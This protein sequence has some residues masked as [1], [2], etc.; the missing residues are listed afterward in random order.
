[1]DS[2]QMTVFFNQNSFEL[3]IDATH[4]YAVLVIENIRAAAAETG[5]EYMRI[6]RDCGAGALFKGAEHR[7]A[8]RDR[9]EVAGHEGFG[10]ERRLLRKAERGRSGRRKGDCNRRA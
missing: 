2:E 1:M 9:R 5:I 3:I 10:Q 7:R 8:A 4:P 6:L